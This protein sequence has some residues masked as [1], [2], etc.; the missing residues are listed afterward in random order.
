MIDDA[1]RW[2][3]SLSS[4]IADKDKQR[5]LHKQTIVG[6]A[7][8]TG[9][10]INAYLDLFFERYAPLNRT[11]FWMLQILIS[12]G[13]SMNQTELAKRV[14]RSRYTI[15]KT[16]DMLEANGWVERKAVQGDRRANNVTITEKGLQMIRDSMDAMA[17]MSQAAVSSLSVEEQ[18]Q[19][20]SINRKLR[21]HL[22]ELMSGMRR[23]D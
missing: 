12:Y 1:T 19:L 9:D 6:S 2:Q 13:G 22:T 7:S 21:D 8:A 16:V 14:F 4:L 3:E 10:V 23:K 20:R 17:G 11:G 18:E 5:S 15:T